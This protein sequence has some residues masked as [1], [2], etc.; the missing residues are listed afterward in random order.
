MIENLEPVQVGPT[1]LP[2]IRTS[3]PPFFGLCHAATSPD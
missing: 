3:D 2:G 1:I